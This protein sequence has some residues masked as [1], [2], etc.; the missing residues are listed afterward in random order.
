MGG[1]Q[2]RI[3]GD[4]RGTGSSRLNPV[5]GLGERKRRLNGKLKGEG[6]H[7][8]HTSVK[9]RVN[10]GDLKVS[11]C[12]RRI[13]GGCYSAHASRERENCTGGGEENRNVVL[14]GKGKQ[15]LPFG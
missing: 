3:R 5:L 10:S 1:I 12:E 9:I 2:E 7:L 6:R 4:G 14:F 15:G 13:A 8:E 11:R